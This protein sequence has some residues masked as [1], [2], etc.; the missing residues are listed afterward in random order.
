[1]YRQVTLYFLTLSLKNK[2]KN[3]FLFSA[4]K[5]QTGSEHHPNFIKK[6][7]LKKKKKE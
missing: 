3:D 5:C 2:T 6:R 4:K 7:K 1:M